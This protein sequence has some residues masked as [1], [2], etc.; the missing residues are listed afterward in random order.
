[1]IQVN[2]GISKKKKIFVLIFK[3]IDGQINS[4]QLLV[5]KDIK[6]N[7]NPL[8]NFFL[9]VECLSNLYFGF[10]QIVIIKMQNGRY[11]KT[12]ATPCGFIDI[13][14]LKTILF[15]Y[16]TQFPLTPARVC[17][18]LVFN[19]LIKKFA[20]SHA[21]CYVFHSTLQGETGAPISLPRQAPP[22]ELHGGGGAPLH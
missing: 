3:N 7:K 21:P 10:K 11:V 18:G 5:F 12:W 1:M 20:Y 9:R 16:S 15:C 14:P 13:N 6:L 8:K 4:I 2:L 19:G 22:R 17:S